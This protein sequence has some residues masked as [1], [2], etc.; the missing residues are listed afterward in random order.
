MDIYSLLA[1]STYS[2][3]SVS[4]IFVYFELINLTKFFSQKKNPVQL[5]WSWHWFSSTENFWT[6]LSETRSRGG[7]RRAAQF[8]FC[9]KTTE[10]W[11]F[12]F[13]A[14]QPTPPAHGP[15]FPS[16]A[17]PRQIGGPDLRPA[18]STLGLRNASWP[19]LD[20][21]NCALGRGC[22]QLVADWRKSGFQFECMCACTYVDEIKCV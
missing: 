15:M 18:A 11:N 10:T 17:G 2:V 20:F 5:R 12:G 14:R 21:E 3:L 9:W 8:F 13:L 7:A 19:G 4:S 1:D 6:W 22:L 16:R